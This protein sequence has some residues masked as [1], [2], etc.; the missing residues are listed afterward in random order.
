MRVGWKEMLPGVI[1]A[2]IVGLGLAM[3][4][5]AHA[6]SAFAQASG[7]KPCGTCHLPGRE[8]DAPQSGF[9]TTG[10]AVHDSFHGTCNYHMDCAINAAFG[11]AAPAA[12]AAP[13]T[14]VAPAANTQSAPDGTTLTQSGRARFRDF[15][16]DTSFFI[17]RPT[18]DRGN[19][20]LFQ[21]KNGHIVHFEVAMGATFASRCGGWPDSNGAFKSIKLE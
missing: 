13:A 10:Q 21:L 16:N 15:C 4:Q 9:T 17:L 18:G 1:A 7:G 19:Q 6:N 2:G 8:T 20:V 3:A 14:L 11:N 12:P 5:P